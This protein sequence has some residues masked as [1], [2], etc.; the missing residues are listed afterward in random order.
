MAMAWRMSS[1]K[2]TPVMTRGDSVLVGSGMMN[3]G[4]GDALVC[5]AKAEVLC[6]RDDLKKHGVKWGYLLGVERAATQEQYPSA[7]RLC[8]VLENEIVTALGAS[9]H[10]NFAFSFCK[11][12]SGPVIK[13]AAGVHHEGLHIDTHP[14]LTETTDLLR[15]LINVD[16]SARCFRFGDVTRLELASS[17]LYSDRTRFEAEHLEG[18]VQ[19]RE[20]VLRGRRGGEV[21]FLLFWA[22]VVPHVG[23]NEALGYFLYSFEAVV[24]SPALGIR[25]HG[26]LR[27]GT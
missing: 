13:E 19:L 12:Y 27:D 6:R 20:C 15:V 7:W 9:R 16:A 5:A 2:I 10:V 26:R 1:L 18:H 24:T 22:S 17:G 11:A 25:P 21:S 4:L 3:S 14:A 23:I 8:A